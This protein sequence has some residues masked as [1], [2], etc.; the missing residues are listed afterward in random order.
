MLKI[1]GLP[2]VRWVLNQDDITR[3]EYYPCKCGCKNIFLDCIKARGTL[4]EL[5]CIAHEMV[6]RIFDIFPNP[7]YEWL[8]LLLDITHG[9]QPELLFKEG[10]D[11]YEDSVILYQWDCLWH[12]E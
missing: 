1:L 10:R 12:T 2:K 8:S 9:N 6:H 3:A 4:V 5:G 7:F 11:S